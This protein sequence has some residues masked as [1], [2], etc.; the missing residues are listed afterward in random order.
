[1]GTRG[2]AYRHDF[3]SDGLWFMLLRVQVPVRR[4]DLSCMKPVLTWLCLCLLL[5]ITVA[6]GQARAAETVAQV[7]ADQRTHGYQRAGDAL[8]RLRHASDVPGADA[9]LKARLAYESAL[10]ALAI[11]NSQ[12]EQIRSG[13]ATLQQMDAHGACPP[14]RFHALLAQARLAMNDVSVAA[15]RP[16]LDEAAALLPGID[17]PVAYERLLAQRGTL[18]ALDQKLDGGIESTMQ[19]LALAEARGDAA[20]VVRLQGALVW[21]N[22]NLGDL[23]RA[24]SLGEEAYA[25]AAAMDYL[26]VMAKISLDLGHAYALANDRKG[27][28]AAIERTLELTRDAPELLTLHLLSLNNLADVYLHQPGQEQRVLDYAGQAESLARENHLDV[29]RAAPLTN[30]GITLARKGELDQGIEHIRRA[31]TISEERGQQDYVVGITRELVGVLERAG[32]FRE[33]LTEL[34]KADTLEH[35]LTRQR[36]DKAV[37]ELQE[38]YAVERKN[39]EIVQLSAQNALKQAEL[40]GESWRNRLWTALALMLAMGSIMLLQAIRRTRRSNRQL[41]VVNASLAEQSITD[42]LTGAANRRHARTRIEQLQHMPQPEHTNTDQAGGIGLLLLDL[43]HFKQV[44]DHHGH[45]AGDAV[46]VAVAQRLRHLLREED[47]IARW[48]GE[49][50]VLILP[51]TSPS[52]LP[53]IAHNVLHAIGD[54][55]VAVAGQIIDITTSLGAVCFPMVPGQRWE[56]ALAV[57]DL[58][59]YQAK[60]D[61]RNRANC[62]TR[63]SPDADASQLSA[64]LAQARQAGDIELT[65]VQGPARTPAVPLRAGEGSPPA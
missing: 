4:A 7:L 37:L 32:Q 14:C 50:F 28:R 40:T 20:A 3:P 49:E 23:G 59:L 57:A 62:L 29:Y 5:V 27:Q 16:Y 34:R 2:V 19:A 26:P 63:V 9:P 10:L 39:Q 53:T 13:L 15:I 31:I 64:G 51:H 35:D 12:I 21:M 36:R 61:G 54:T 45:A 52:A 58:A 17:D 55:P 22:T 48:G 8:T 33:A 65:T 47:T 25:R 1:M 18:E 42:P 56:A 11:D 30:I 6:P 38:K 41:K 24:T 46:L 44:N 60:A 43:D